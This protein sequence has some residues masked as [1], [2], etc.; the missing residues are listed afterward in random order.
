[1]N[2]PYRDRRKIDPAKGATLGDGTPN[3]NDRVEIGP[4]QLAFREWE[5]AGLALPDLTAM[6]H[7]RWQRLID[8][9][10][11]ARLSAGSSCSTR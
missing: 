4:T 7:D 8:A 5:A 9:A 1:M 2:Q 3:D 11:R 10:R 6:R